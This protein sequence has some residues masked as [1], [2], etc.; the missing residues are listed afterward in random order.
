MI[1]ANL[2]AAEAVLADLAVLGF[3]A[4]TGA[5]IEA[6]CAAVT[7]TVSTEAFPGALAPFVDGAGAIMLRDF[8]RRMRLARGRAADEQRQRVLLALHLLRDMD[9]LVE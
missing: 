1:G 5:D 6:L 7:Q 2:A 4:G 8:D 9:H 3:C